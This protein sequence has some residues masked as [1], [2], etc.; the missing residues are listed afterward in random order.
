V[1]G[2]EERESERVKGEFFRFQFFKLVFFS[3]LVKNSLSLSL[4]RNSISKNSIS[5]NSLSKNSLS[6]NSLSLSISLSFLPFCLPRLL[7]K[8][9]LASSLMLASTR[10][11]PVFP[12]IHALKAA[13]APGPF[14]QTT[15][16]FLDTPVSA[17]IRDPCLRA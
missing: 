16:F 11:F 7:I 6:K 12:S 8:P 3:S 1:G 17:K 14:L 2:F 5:K 10:G 15:P 4:S 9:V 13:S